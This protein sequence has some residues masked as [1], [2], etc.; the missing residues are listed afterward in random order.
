M[1]KVRR[2][3]M[4]TTG[5]IVLAT[6]GSPG[7]ARAGL[8]S[9]FDLVNQGIIHDFP[10]SET[11]F[12]PNSLATATSINYTFA[13]DTSL[14]GS[15]F[16]TAGSSVPASLYFSPAPSGSAG[17]VPGTA[18]AIPG[19]S[20]IEQQVDVDFNIIG[21]GSVVLLAGELQGTLT[22]DTSNGAGNIMEPI[23]H[24]WI[25]DLVYAGNPTLLGIGT[26]FSLANIETLNGGPLG[27]TAQGNISAF[28]ADLAGQFAS[29]PE[30]T[31]LTI[32]GLGLIVMA[33]ASRIRR[34]LAQDQTQRTCHQAGE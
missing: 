4:I 6:F 3:S 16:A 24:P 9:F 7:I 32:G 11:T 27:I 12:L 28:S 31:S 20:L 2:F 23:P 34:R 8:L 15:P 33:M 25:S 22:I 5:V 17:T 1:T 13:V 29:V 26:V 10:P 18:V 14:N 21:Q 30:P 19:T